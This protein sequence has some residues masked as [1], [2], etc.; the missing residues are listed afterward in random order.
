MPS[1]IML[2]DTLQMHISINQ[3]PN[4]RGTRKP[5]PIT[6]S[7]S[8]LIFDRILSNRELLTGLLTSQLPRFSQINFNSVKTVIAYS[9]RKSRQT[10]E[11]WLPR[12]S[13][14]HWLLQ[15]HLLW[16]K[17]PQVCA[18][19]IFVTGL[20]VCS[21]CKDCIMHILKTWC[22]GHCSDFSAQ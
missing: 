6:S 13:Q 7:A 15:S 2:S 14:L 8:S 21:R 17:T 4:Y 12:W 9:V 20:T 10:L 22:T 1:A 16:S 11:Q 18:I 19:S 3:C 5:N